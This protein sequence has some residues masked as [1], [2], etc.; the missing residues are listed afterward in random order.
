[1]LSAISA[2]NKFNQHNSILI[3]N[4]SDGDREQN[5]KQILNLVG[6]EWHEVYIQKVVRGKVN[7]LLKL[8]KNMLYFGFKYRG[9]IDKY[10]F[11]EYR[12]VEMAIM[13]KVLSPEESILL[14]DGAFTIIA[15]S[16]YIKNNISPYPKTNTYKM[17]KFFINNINVPNLYSFF[18]LD[19]FLLHGQV[20]YFGFQ[21]KKKAK[22]IIGDVFFFGTKFSESNLMHLVDEMNVL[23]NIFDMYGNY[24]VFYIPHRDESI[25]KLDKISQL[26]FTIK[27]LEKPAEIYFDE[28]DTMP[29]IVAAYYSTVLCTC[30]LRYDNVKLHSIDITNFLLKES[31]KFHVEETYKYYK[32]L[33][34]QLVDIEVE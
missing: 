6:P 9:N 11:G 7:V 18:E 33:G 20:N 29:E 22:I 5:D 32:T 26:G 30:L 1:M 25:A 17:F 8:L 21:N 13:N 16:Y 14:D 15:Q 27:N 2:L 31:T 19:Q 3:V 23:S 10:F 12:N 28:T 34:I 24:K 4:I